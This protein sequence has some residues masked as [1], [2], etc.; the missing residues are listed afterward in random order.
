MLVVL[1]WPLKGH[2]VEALAFIPLLWLPVFVGLTRISL[3]KKSTGNEL[4]LLGIA[5]WVLLQ[6]FA[7]VHA[8]GHDL[9]AIPSRYTDIVVMGVLANF[10]LAI[11]WAS[12]RDESRGLRNMSAAWLLLMLP[13]MTLIM[14]H[15][16]P[17]D[18]SAMAGRGTYAEIETL[19]VSGFIATGND[20]YLEHPGLEIP[21]PSAS[22]LKRY[23][24][25]PG[26]RSMILPAFD[27]GLT[28]LAEALRDHERILASRLGM[29]HAPAQFQPLSALPIMSGEI[30]SPALCTVDMLNEGKPTAAV[31]M[32]QGGLFS[33]QG[34]IVWR[35]DVS[36]SNEAV[37]MLSDR[38][39]YRIDLDMT[40]N[41]PDVV[42]ALH[43]VPSL[44]R[45]F[46]VTAPLG[47]VL[48]GTYT[49]AIAKAAPPHAAIYCS[50]PITLS[51]TR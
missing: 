24:L 22:A 45:G 27:A 39:H 47:Q 4:F 41:R 31:A 5:G 50:L 16:T 19:N 34:W 43:S 36:S 40:A 13:L 25:D 49:V 29:S 33:I 20:G 23:L 35:E 17:G 28:R 51:V 3:P 32:P 15:R 30:K 9:T 46:S 38:A 48:P 11:L 44:T 2:H 21:Y 14:I 7:I 1:M 6:G 42:K 10:T 8:R 37:L 26:M 18:V 12:A